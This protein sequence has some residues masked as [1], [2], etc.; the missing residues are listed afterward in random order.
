MTADFGDE[1]ADISGNVRLLTQK[2]KQEAPAEGEAAP[3]A[4]EAPAP[5]GEGKEGRFE[6][7]KR[8][9]TTVTCQQIRYWY[10]EKR[11]LATGNVLAEQEDK[12]VY[13][14]EALYVEKDDLL[15]LTGNPVTA[16]MENGNR[17]TTPWVKVEVE[18]ERFWTGG[19][20]GTFKKEKTEEE[21]PAEGEPA[22]P[23]GPPTVPPPPTQPNPDAQ[24]EAP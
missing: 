8:K 7:H 12:K 22:P 9:L 23:N 14:D 13:A 2:K 5:E 10:E 15:T 4:G 3:K 16:V 11:A 1:V 24:P 17:F 18:G 19:F 20:S 21:K 6:E